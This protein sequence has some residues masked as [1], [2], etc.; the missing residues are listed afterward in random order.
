MADI[1][2]DEGT[3]A[4]KDG[5][6]IFYQHWSVPKPKAVLAVAHGLGEHSGRY[7][8][9]VELLNPLGYSVWALDHRGHGRSEGKRGHVMR[10]AEFLEDL[11]QFLDL[12]RTKE[13]A[14]LF[15]MGHSMGGLIADSFA[16]S[17]PQGIAGLVSSSAAL[18]L[19]LEVPK[20]KAMVGRKLS[21]LWPGLAMGNGLKPTDLSHDGRV[22]KAYIEDP[23]VHDRV[24]A[25]FFTEFTGQMTWALQHAPDLRMPCLIVH[26]GDDPIVSPEGSRQFYETCGSADKQLKIYDGFYHESFNEIK[27]DLPLGDLSAWLDA[28]A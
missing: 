14:K 20:L 4:S 28:H 26:G 3:F 24:T 25:R 23:L 12:V 21:D 10:F 1:V 27:K 22:V 7:G 5:T 19:R 9:V 6:E 17:R 2:H 13:P 11:G 15:L 8:N 16:L 18:K